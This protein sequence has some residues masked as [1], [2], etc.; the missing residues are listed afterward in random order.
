MKW[1]GEI[2]GGKVFMLD[3]ANNQCSGYHEVW[4]SGNGRGCTATG[5]RLRVPCVLLGVDF[6]ICDAANDGAQGRLA[7]V[8]VAREHSFTTLRDLSATQLKVL[9]AT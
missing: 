8:R 4:H 7:A 5:R 6:R 3:K 2:G 9:V 1:I